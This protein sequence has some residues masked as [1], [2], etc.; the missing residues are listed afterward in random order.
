MGKPVTRPCDKCGRN[1]AERFYSG[2]RGKICVTCR[3]RTRS[4]ASHD[5]R[6][7]ETY[8][9]ALG[10]YASLFEAQGRVCAI[11][12]QPR[13]TRLDV[14]HNHANNI[15]RGLLCRLCNRRLLT[16]ARDNPETLRAA[17]KYLENPPAV[18]YLGERFYKDDK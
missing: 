12:K 7:S 1:R 9:L 4:A 3:K 13:T 18:F 10:E 2:P 17:A 5:K 6:V 11:C 16:A 14:D 8:G 15:I